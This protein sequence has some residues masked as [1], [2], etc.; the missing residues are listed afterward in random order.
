MYFQSQVRKLLLSQSMIPYANSRYGIIYNAYVIFDSRNICP[1]GW[2]VTTSPEY[3]TIIN[4]SGGSAVSGQNL[5]SIG[6]DWWNTANGLNTYG[7]NF[8]GNGQRSS[9]FLGF[10]SSGNLWTSTIISQQFTTSRYLVVTDLAN[11]A[12]LNAG[13][14]S[15]GK[16][17]R[18]AKDSTTLSNGQTSTM[19]GTDG[20]QYNTICIGGIEILSEN[21]RSA[22]Y[23]NGDWIT[24]FD[25]GVYTPISN[26][27]WAAKTTEA[28]CVY[29]DNLSNM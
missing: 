27:A 23:R 14:W 1:V 16:G 11:N 24:G 15:E 9:G 29:G 6:T 4:Y 19:I 17:I 13:A 22:N 21:Y 5:K 12:E 3:T 2:H 26:A 10:K 25:G 18:L 28:C 20:R 8:R 7:F